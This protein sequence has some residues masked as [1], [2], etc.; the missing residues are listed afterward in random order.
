MASGES[1]REFPRYSEMH[2]SSYLQ[3]RIVRCSAHLNRRISDEIL[4]KSGI[5]SECGHPL[6]TNEVQ[7]K[8]FFSKKN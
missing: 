5:P 2:V 8:A 1:F 3:I 6:N 7:I 4:K